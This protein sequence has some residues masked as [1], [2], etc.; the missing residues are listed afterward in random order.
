[1]LTRVLN[2]GSSSWDFP[3]CSKLR[4]VGGIIVYGHGKR[5]LSEW[6]RAVRTSEGTKSRDGNGF[7]CEG[8]T[9]PTQDTDMNPS[10][11]VVQFDEPPRT[12]D[13]NWASSC[14][15]FL[16]SDI[17]RTRT[18]TAVVV[19]NDYSDLRKKQH[20][21]STRMSTQGK[22][23]PTSSRDKKNNERTAD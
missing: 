3:E 2:L 15:I 5:P 17:R 6:S 1:M 8:K 9:Q 23:R 11:R 18:T 14:M 10:P 21:N 20:S 22:G 13:T 4:S 7:K 16:N 12:P 19:K